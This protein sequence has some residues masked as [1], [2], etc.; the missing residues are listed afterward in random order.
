M[1]GTCG[2]VRDEVGSYA[3][4]GEGSMARVEDTKADADASGLR[5]YG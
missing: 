1:Y 3:T 2:M 5:V 4:D